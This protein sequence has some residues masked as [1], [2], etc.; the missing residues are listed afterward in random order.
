MRL[1]K[2]FGAWWTRRSSAR[3]SQ[4][5]SRIA[6]FLPRRENGVWWFAGVVLVIATT[7]VLLPASFRRSVPDMA[8]TDRAQQVARRNTTPVY[9][10]DQSELTRAEALF[11]RIQDILDIPGLTI[12]ERT[13]ALEDFPLTKYYLND[14]EVDTL[15]EHSVHFA[16]V[17][18]HTLDVVSS[19]LSRGVVIG[20]YGAGSLRAELAAYF[21]PE[22]T[23]QWHDVESMTIHVLPDDRIVPIREALVWEDAIVEVTRL[24]LAIDFG[25]SIDPETAEALRELI[26]S[27]CRPLIRPNLYYNEQ[28]TRDL[29]ETNA[30]SVPVAYRS[31]HQRPLG[32]WL[33]TFL[34]AAMVAIL[35]ALF[36]S[37]QPRLT[38]RNF[39]PIAALG[40]V[41]AG[42]LLLLYFGTRVVLRQRDVDYPILVIPVSIAASVASI[43][44]GSTTGGFVTVFLTAAAGMMSGITAPTSVPQTWVL[45]VSGFSASYAMSDIHHRRD[46][47]YAGIWVSVATMIAVLG[48]ALLPGDVATKEMLRLVLWALASGLIVTASVPGVLPP[49]E[50]LSATV[51]DME[52]LE[53]TD[54]NHPL[55]VR[56]QSVAP[57][58]YNHSLNVARL[59]EGAAE[60]IGANSLLARTGA[61]FHDIGKMTS[62]EYFIENQEGG[63]NPHDRL[64][65]TLSARVLIAHVTDGIEMAKEHKL[66]RAIID[67]IPQ[68]HG[69]S[70]IRFFYHKAAAHGDVVNEAEFRYPGPKPHDKV[71]AIL[72]LADSIEAAA[73]ARFKNA[74]GLTHRDCENHVAS[75]INQ[76]LL[77][78]QLDE[79]D[80]T[81][82]DLRVISS[83][84]Q[85]MLL[86]MYHSRIDYPSGASPPKP[87]DESREPHA[88][89]V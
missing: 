78:G 2:L 37:T 23:T 74:P 41:L 61:L 81:Q 48:V 43:L 63:P 79:C 68:H 20:G 84:Y 17:K 15:L 51:T 58:T 86:G 10:L 42:A 57:G 21:D 29:Q 54:Q 24:V 31:T 16:A 83:N 85:R 82:N 33:G 70:L 75:I 38:S 88:I 71:G 3:T 65:P 59:A 30:A 28:A 80:L 11:D 64:S 34:L 46:V 55:L 69:T 52:L 39:R 87:A 25:P 60:A 56:M 45:L 18:R 9:T 67:L 72:L 76:H 22:L 44:M 73:N 26:E 66:P 4:A 1:P 5:N 77:D 13:Q 7:F 12:E 27:L 47:V 62:P 36:A 6:R 49:L 53:L 89:P 19:T 50:Y 32:L 14:V 40:V 8:A 35:T